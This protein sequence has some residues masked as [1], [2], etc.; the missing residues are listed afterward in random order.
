MLLKQDMTAEPEGEELTSL[1]NKSRSLQ[2]LLFLNRF[3]FHYKETNRKKRTVGC[4]NKQNGRTL[5]KFLARYVNAQ[6]MC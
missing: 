1:D 5:Q 6:R 2:H 4:R 3:S